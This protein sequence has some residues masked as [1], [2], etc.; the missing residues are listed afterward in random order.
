M[1]IS[2][3][4]FSASPFPDPFLGVGSGPTVPQPPRLPT[5]RDTAGNIWDIFKAGSG[6]STMPDAPGVVGDVAKQAVKGAST[7]LG[8]DLLRIVILILGIICVIGAI[9]LFK[10]TQE[11]VAAPARALA[12]AA[13]AAAA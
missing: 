5:I 11:L 7:L 8:L 9:Y 13:P 3:G 6:V 4:G 12:A 2:I 1:P 10:P